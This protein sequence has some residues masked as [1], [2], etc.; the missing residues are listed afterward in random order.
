MNKLIPVVI[1]GAG[2]FLVGCSDPKLVNDVDYIT[3]GNKSVYG[4]FSPDIYKSSSLLRTHYDVYMPDNT[5]PQTMD[6]NDPAAFNQLV[7]I[8]NNANVTDSVTFYIQGE[9]GRLDSLTVVKNAMANTKASIKIVVTGNVY[10]ASAMF[11]LGVED[12]EIN[13]HTVLMFH[14]PAS[15]L[16]NKTAQEACVQFAGQKDRGQ[17]AQAKCEG[18]VNLFKKTSS[19]MMGDFLA[20]L[21]TVLTQE[22]IQAV[23]DGYDVFITGKTLKERLKGDFKNNDKTLYAPT[24]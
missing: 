24:K 13:D 17:D 5:T 18:Y 19:E 7:E 11:V 6:F 21:K 1:L 12:V 20:S 8:L 4:T 2:L 15:A 16:D 23:A 3:G 22:E 10:S 14:R 9:G